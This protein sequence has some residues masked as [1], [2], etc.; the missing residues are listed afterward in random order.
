MLCSRSCTPKLTT[1]QEC[2]VIYL[3]ERGRGGPGRGLSLASAVVGEAPT[4]PPCFGSL[5]LAAAALHVFRY[6]LGARSVGTGV[7]AKEAQTKWASTLQLLVQ[8][9]TSILK[10]WR[11][12]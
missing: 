7:V 11:P 10:V 3:L 4:G 9:W 12:S 8:L 2:D 5:L 6:P 1:V